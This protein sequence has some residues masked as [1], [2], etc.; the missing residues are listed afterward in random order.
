M[1]ERGAAALEKFL[2][3]SVESIRA[4]G[5]PKNDHESISAYESALATVTAVADAIKNDGVPD[6]VEPSDCEAC[7]NQRAMVKDPGDQPAYPVCMD[8]NCDRYVDLGED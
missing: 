4:H 2:R 8:P 1:T 3:A 7:G 5:Q 6:A